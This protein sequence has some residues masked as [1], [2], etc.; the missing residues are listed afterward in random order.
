MLF[1]NLG[2]KL[3]S[4]GAGMLLQKSCREVIMACLNI[5]Q[6]KKLLARRFLKGKEVKG[7]RQPAAC[8]ILCAH[9]MRPLVSFWSGNKLHLFS[10]HSCSFLCP[11]LLIP[12]LRKSQYLWPCL[13][14]GAV[15]QKPIVTC[16]GLMGVN[17]T[18]TEMGS[19]WWSSIL[20]P[21]LSC[22][23]WTVVRHSMKDPSCSPTSQWHLAFIIGQCPSSSLVSSNVENGFFPSSFFFFNFIEICLIYNVVLIPVVKQSDL[24]IHMCVCVYIYIYFIIFFSIMVYHRILNSFLCYTVG[25]CCLSKNDFFNLSPL[26]LIFLSPRIFTLYIHH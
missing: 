3:S 18:W 25:P 5:I 22:S 11:T 21:N 23:E 20:G 4:M 8:S 15:S 10:A 24:V 14:C 19:L 7:H 2:G 6:G 12:V 1:T 17:R 26:G 16:Q 9:L 13:P